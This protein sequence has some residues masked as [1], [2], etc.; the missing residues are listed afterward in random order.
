MRTSFL[1]GLGLLVLG[2]ALF[3]IGLNSTQSPTEQVVETLTGRYTDQTMWYM[4]VGGIAFLGGCVLAV[5]G[6]TR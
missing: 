6:G 1:L 3:I 4:I 2:V 5:R